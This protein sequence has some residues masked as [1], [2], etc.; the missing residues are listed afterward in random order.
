MKFKCLLTNHLGP[1]DTLA[2][3]LRK[4]HHLLFLKLLEFLSFSKGEKM[5]EK[6]GN[7]CYPKVSTDQLHAFWTIQN[8]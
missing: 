8:G 1:Y 3:S 7:R 5:K 4:A 2:L 6:K